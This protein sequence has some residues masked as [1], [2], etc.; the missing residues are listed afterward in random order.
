MKHL[1]LS[2]LLLYSNISIGQENKLPSFISDSLETYIERGMKDWQIPGLSIAI[3]KDG[4]IVYMKGFG[5]TEKDGQKINENTLFMIGSNT[6]AFTGAALASLHVAGKMDLSD[7]VIKWMPE[8]HLKDTFATNEIIVSD[9]LSHQTGLKHLRGDF[10][11]WS[12]PLTRKDVIQKMGVIES[13]HMIRT[14]FG[15]CNSAF[16]AA[17]ELIPRIINK[18]WEET[19]FDSII[20]PLK[21]ERT[22]ML[23]KEVRKA[24]NVAA[25]HTFVDGKLSKIPIM[26]VDNLGPAG[27]MSSSASDMAKWLQALISNGKVDNHQLIDSRII[28]E[29][30]RPYSIM[31]I[32]PRDN[33]ITH[34][35]LYGLGLLI[36]DCDGKLLYYHDGGLDGY[37][38]SVMVIP[39]EQLGIVVLT[40]ND[41]NNF[42]A[43]LA[44]EIRD[45][46]L[47]LPYKGYSNKSLKKYIEKKIVDDLYIDSL[48]NIISQMNKPELTFNNYCGKYTNEIYG[49]IEVKQQNEKLFI[50]FSNHPD[51]IGAL[52][53]IKD[54]V[55]LCSY[56]KPNF[57]IVEIPFHIE[58]KTVKGLT[59]SV[60]DFIEYY[61]YEFQKK[62]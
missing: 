40:N 31:G 9:L 33:Q 10:S 62:E 19:V 20:E 7:K 51:L 42:Y 32:D 17:G 49:E 1:I 16:V 6:K 48:K 43:D 27:S 36:N 38:S 46:F 37:L 2:I 4:Q 57:G 12:S 45:A 58:Q 41:F 52:E 56:S 29:I 5:V 3:V 25:P 24:E 23:S 22:L 15:Y 44:D 61:P 35:Y 30:K 55:F 14:K 11:Y 54:N 28:K 18:T 60:S 53:Y 13:S 26:D 8:F 34:F 39:E 21:M 59:L 47:G 50:K